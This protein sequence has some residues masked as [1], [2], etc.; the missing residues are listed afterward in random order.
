MDA[1]A[2]RADRGSRERG[3]GEGGQ[4]LN[5]FLSLQVHSANLRGRG[6]RITA[7]MAAAEGGGGGRRRMAAAEGP[8]TAA[9]QR[10]W[11]AAS[12]SECLR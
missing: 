4:Y 12:V 3:E 7:W 9:W 5:P 2:C 1:A 10:C 11:W 8:I 6:A